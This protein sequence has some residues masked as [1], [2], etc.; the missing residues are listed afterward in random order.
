MIVFKYLE[1]ESKTAAYD[2]NREIGRC[3][4]DKLGSNLW[5]IICTF[6]EEPY[7]GNGIGK[8]MLEMVLDN[9]VRKNVKIIP[10]CDFAHMIMYKDTKHEGL[11]YRK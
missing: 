1:N 8:K 4:Y 11:L 6:V 9:A 5:D 10:T 7:R 3:S 2:G